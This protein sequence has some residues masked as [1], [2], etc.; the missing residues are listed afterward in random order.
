MEA[1]SRHDIAVDLRVGCLASAQTNKQTKN[2]IHNL[3]VKMQQLCSKDSI[4]ILVVCRRSS[5]FLWIFYVKIVSKVLPAYKDGEEPMVE[6][7]Y[8]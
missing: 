6:L 7:G 1:T 3:M 5:F 4:S 8:G 2:F